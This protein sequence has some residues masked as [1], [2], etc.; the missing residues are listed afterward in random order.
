MG[1][2]VPLIFNLVADELATTPKSCLTDSPLGKV[3]PTDPFC[4]VYVHVFGTV[5]QV[6]VPCQK[7]SLQEL[8]IN[9]RKEVA[10]FRMVCFRSK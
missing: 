1:Q 10:E 6:Q 9:V 7:S 4:I 5:L 3:Q 8:S 2:V